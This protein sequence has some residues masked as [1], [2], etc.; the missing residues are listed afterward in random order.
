MF[1]FFASPLSGLRRKSNKSIGLKSPSPNTNRSLLIAQNITIIAA[2]H[3]DSSILFVLCLLLQSLEG[4]K[5]HYSNSAPEFNLKSWM[6]SSYQLWL[7]IGYKA[8]FFFP[9]LCYGLLFSFALDTVNT[10]HCRAMDRAI[11]FWVNKN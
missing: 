4:I 7:L 6:A 1:L 3:K 8:L 9:S 10:E 11:S 2:L 5:A